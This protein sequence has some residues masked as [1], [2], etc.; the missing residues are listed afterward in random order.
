MGLV[1]FELGALKSLKKLNLSGN[2]IEG[3][4]PDEFCLEEDATSDY[5]LESIIFDCMDPPLV[6]CDCCAPCDGDDSSGSTTSGNP[7]IIDYLAVFGRRGQRIAEVLEVVTEGI[8]ARGSNR[9]AAAEWI[10]KEDAMDMEHSDPLLLQRFVLA[11]LHFQLDGSNWVYDKYLTKESEC[12]WDGITCN[13][14]NQV[15][16]IVLCEFC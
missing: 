3:E 4:A 10:I 8:Y 14:D 6:D 7:Q 9:A 1:P 5:A 15:T 2:F 12:E 16:D 11:L 13:D